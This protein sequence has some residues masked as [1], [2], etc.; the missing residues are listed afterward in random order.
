MIRGT[1]YLQSKVDKLW[2][3]ILAINDVNIE[4]PLMLMSLDFHDL[5]N[6]AL[7]M[8]MYCILGSPA[9]LRQT[10]SCIF[11]FK[12]CIRR[13]R[14]RC[15]ECWAMKWLASPLGQRLGQSQARGLLDLPTHCMPTAI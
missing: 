15:L 11:S 9:V 8:H 13:G 12:N 14:E 7:S 6:R 5:R 2:Y 4:M 1:A 10:E 3:N